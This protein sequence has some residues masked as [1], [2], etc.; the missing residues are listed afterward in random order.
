M[1]C[2]IT[3]DGVVVEL[4]S[5][6]RLSASRVVLA[7]GGGDQP[8]WPEWAPKNDPRVSHVFAPDFDG[9][10]TS[11]ESVGVFGGGISGAQ[12]ALRLAAEGHEVHL[13]SRH[14]LREHQFDSE[15]GW[16]G[17][18]FMTGFASESDMDR[19]RTIISSAPWFGSTGRASRA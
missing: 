12:I 18:R 10:P 14:A 1:E 7:I 15:P 2:A 4:D 8:E 3:C 16:L 6:E 9:W 5:G 11:K 13:V 17:P 19:R